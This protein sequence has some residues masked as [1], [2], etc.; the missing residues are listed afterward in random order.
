VTSRRA[1]LTASIAVTVV[2]FAAVAQPPAKSWRIGYL[3]PVSPSAGARLLE[4]FRQGLRELGYVEGQNIS[5][6]YRWTEGRPDRFPALAAELTQLR[7]D[8]IVTYNNPAVAALQQATRTIPIVVAN[9][10]DPVGSGFV[11][12]LARPGGN[13][14]GF[15]GLS[16]ELSRK[17]VEL[18]REA[19]PNVSRVAVL[20]VSLTPA[21]HNH[22]W[23]EIQGAA[24]ALQV[25]P[26]RHEIAGPDEIEHAFVSLIKSRA[27]GLIV[28]PHPVTNAHRTQ[29][30][31]LAA[32]HRLPGTYPDSQY[33][34]AGGLMSYTA[35][36]SDLHRRAA[37]VVDKIL[38]GAR[39]ADLP[40]QQPTTFELA[41]N[42]R[43]AKALG[44]TIPRSLLV[45]ADQVIE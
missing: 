22:Q 21:S 44:L 24:K 20:T 14:T 9:M 5:I 18:L 10:G 33:V 4:S 40:I 35:N 26:Q 34:E 38:R 19:V 12:S 29:I 13:I 17:W 42:L 32:E 8:V 23:R 27:Q 6:D 31:N 15:S 36:F 11:A 25:T 30:V 1:F 16:E 2:P 45:R 37:T 28:L 41:I 3:G 43:T 39:P 7:V